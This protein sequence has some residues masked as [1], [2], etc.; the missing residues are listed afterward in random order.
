MKHKRQHLHA[1]TG[2]RTLALGV[3]TLNHKFIYHAMEQSSIE[4]ALGSEFK[5][6]IAVKGCLVIKAHCNVAQCS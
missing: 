6:I 2:R 4:K 5:E 1:K 3:T